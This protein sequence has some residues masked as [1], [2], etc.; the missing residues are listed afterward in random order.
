MELHICENELPYL[1][2][3]LFNNSH[4]TVVEA[5]TNKLSSLPSLHNKRW[6]CTSLHTFRAAQNHLKT[7]PDAMVGALNLKN[8]NLSK[9]QLEAFELAW[10]C[11][12]VSRHILVVHEMKMIIFEVLISKEERWKK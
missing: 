9:N 10:K 12:L 8:L 7:L 5:F 1:P 2:I 3:E 11:P 6:K 4:I